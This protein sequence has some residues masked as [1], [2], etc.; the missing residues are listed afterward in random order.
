MSTCD[1]L[2]LET[3]GSWPIMPKNLPRHCSNFIY[4]NHIVYMIHHWFD[5]CLHW[6]DWIE[7]WIRTLMSFVVTLHKV[8]QF[9]LHDLR[10]S[11]MCKQ[12]LNSSLWSYCGHF[13]VHIQF[14]LIN[15]IRRCLNWSTI[16]N[17]QHQHCHLKIH[18]HN[19]T[20][21]QKLDEVRAEISLIPLHD[22][23]RPL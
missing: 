5:A 18:N 17:H 15:R 22:F 21:M 23:Y 10:M 1:R 6:R 4:A 16:A 20:K 12:T 7:L 11:N 14:W 2:D 3:L 9:F 13:Q 8:S 19:F